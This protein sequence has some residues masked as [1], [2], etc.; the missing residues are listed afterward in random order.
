MRLLCA[1]LLVGIATASVVTTEDMDCRVE[2]IEGTL[3]D[4]TSEEYFACLSGEG[5][6]TPVIERRLANWDAATLRANDPTLFDEAITGQLR[7]RVHGRRGAG[8]DNLIVESFSRLNHPLAD[9][10]PGNGKGHGRNLASG[11]VSTIPTW[12]HDTLV[13][14]VDFTDANFGTRTVEEQR[15]A[16]FTPDS[17]SL[18]SRFLDMTDGLGVMNDV[19]VHRVSI[20][21]DSSTGCARSTWSNAADSILQGQGVNVGAARYRM[22]MFPNNPCGGI[23]WGSVCNG[24]CGSGRSWYFTTSRDYPLRGVET[25]IHELGHNQGMTHA[26]HNGEQY[27]DRSCVMGYATSSIMGGWNAAHAWYM[28]YYHS[29]GQV[30]SLDQAS[31]QGDVQVTLT[32]ATRFNSQGNGVLI[33]EILGNTGGSGNLYVSFIGGESFHAQ[34]TSTW[35]NKVGITRWDDPTRSNTFTNSAGQL[36]AGGK[37]THGD[38]TITANSIDTNTMTAVITISF[39]VLCTTDADCSDGLFCNGVETCTATGCAAGSAPCSDNN[40]CDG[41][42]VCNEDTDV[43]D[44][45]PFPGCDDGDNCNGIESC[46]A[47]FGCVP[48]TPPACGL[49]DGCCPDGCNLTNDPNCGSVCGDGFCSDGETCSGTSSAGACGSDCGA[50]GSSQ[51][52]NGVC[53]AGD[54]ENCVNCPNDCSGRQSGKPSNRFCCGNGGGERPVSCSDSRC[55]SNDLTCTTTSSPAVCACGDGVCSSAERCSGTCLLDILACG[56]VLSSEASCTDG[57]D[58]DCDGF[59]DCADSDCSADAACVVTCANS[60]ATCSSNAQC[61]S[62][63][64]RGKGGRK[65][66]Q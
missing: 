25:W 63:R 56:P 45:I 27:A 57:E 22:Y 13:V 48:G 40:V 64:C 30:V 54:G 3:T 50:V 18:Y 61:C 15:A 55:S 66:C 6:T 58:D 60:G 59:V 11:F 39:P 44:V 29:N 16:I 2:L 7:L 32:S 23:A 4:F 10:Q 36:V 51:C 41:S 24:G 28:G 17:D 65:T 14:M 53:E 26:N 38:I 19:G 33:V 12:S 49:D 34:V 52:G 5:L 21:Y 46:D 8:S 20:N 47:A 42:N 9:G 62:N 43:C 1:V 37:I 31:T 35:R